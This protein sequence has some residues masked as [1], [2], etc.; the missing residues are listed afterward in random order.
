[1]HNAT[2]G[3]PGPLLRVIFSTK[4]S[5]RTHP[6]SPWNLYQQILWF[7]LFNLVFFQWSGQLWE[8]W[9][10]RIF[11]LKLHVLALL[12]TCTCI[13]RLLK[14]RL[15]APPSRN[16]SE[17]NTSITVSLT[18]SQK[19]WENLWMGQLRSPS[20]FLPGLTKP[21]CKLF[22]L[23]VLLWGPESTVGGCSAFW[24]SS[25]SGTLNQT[26]CAGPA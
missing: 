25:T 21:I 13:L 2:T 19:P 22:L 16:W 7:V 3:R 23:D 24:A 20:C 11:I 8:I 4:Y 9:D 12:Y 5:T 6:Y 14:R 17:I 26:L 10:A 18:G 1:M 15:K